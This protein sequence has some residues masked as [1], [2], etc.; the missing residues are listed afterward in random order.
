MTAGEVEIN[1]RNT[2]VPDV[3]FK[4]L[5]GEATLNLSGAWKNNML[6]DIRGGFGSIT[7]ILPSD[8]G[9]ELEISG[10]LGDVDAPRMRKDGN[11]YFNKAFGETAHTLYLDVN[12]GIG[13]VSVEWVED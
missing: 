6:A 5:A 1:L 10:I 3:D 12:G 13:D 9:V 2:S 8:V 4:A 11:T 7:L